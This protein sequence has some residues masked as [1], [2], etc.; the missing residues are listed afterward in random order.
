MGSSQQAAMNTR[1][2][3]LEASGTKW[4]G[5]GQALNSAA[6]GVSGITGGIG[7]I[8]GAGFTN[9]ADLADAKRAELEA[10]AKVHETAVGHASDLMQQM[11]DI[12]RDIRDKLSSIE[13][14]TL[15]TNRGI[16]R[17]I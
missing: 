6:M 15:E 14:A 1:A 11:M 2:N 5:T 12:I 17:N 8:V 4:T 13:Q 7:G 16:A 10:Q 3:S 9:K